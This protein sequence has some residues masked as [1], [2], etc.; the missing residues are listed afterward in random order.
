MVVLLQFQFCRS[1]LIGCIPNS[2]TITPP[3]SLI[4][5][6]AS[7]AGAR[8]VSCKWRKLVGAIFHRGKE[9]RKA[10]A[11]I[12]AITVICPRR[13]DSFSSHLCYFPTYDLPSRIFPHVTNV[14]EN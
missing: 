8:R 5:H 10:A 3:P 9:G 7:E 12:T 4:I 6:D 11:I 1:V 14:K 13:E 2:Q